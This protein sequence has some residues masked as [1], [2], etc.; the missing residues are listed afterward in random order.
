[1]TTTPTR[2]EFYA[3]AQGIIDNTPTPMLVAVIAHLLENLYRATHDLDSDDN[4]G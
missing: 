2:N 4:E 3:S 1:M